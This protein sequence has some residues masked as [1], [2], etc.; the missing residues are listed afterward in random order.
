MQI[1]HLNQEGLH[2]SEKDAINALAKA[3]PDSWYGFASLEMF[4]RK[5]GSFETD[6]IILTHDRIIVAELKCWGGTI[7]SR[8][9]K[10]IIDWGNSQE[11][12]KHPIKQVSRAAKILSAKIQKKLERKVFI[13]WVD[14]CVILCGTAGKANLPDDEKGFVYTVDEFSQFGSP[15][16]YQ[17]V[18]TPPY[19]RYNP[20][21]N[22]ERPNQNINIWKNFFTGNSVDF[23]PKTFSVNNY[24]Q[25]GM[26]LYSHGQIYSEYLAQ[27]IDDSNYKSLMRRWDFSAPALVEQAQT[28]E[29]RKLIG[30]RESKVLGYLASQDESLQQ[31]HLQ[32]LYTPS[33]NDITTDFV[34]LYKWPG[35]RLRLDDFIAKNSKKISHQGRIELIKVF[36]SQLARLH[37]VDVAHRDIGKHSVWLSLPSK[38]TFS[39]FLTASYPDP[40]QQ[41]V[42]SVRDILKSGRIE[43]PEDLYEDKD[44]TAFTR[45]VYLAG[46]VAHYIAYD[47]WPSKLED[48]TYGWISKGDTFAGGLLD[49]WFEHCLDLEAKNR[50]SNMGCAL[51]ELNKLLS[52]Q[53]TNNISSTELEKFYSDTNVYM[54]YAPALIKQK[55]TASSLMRS[56][57]GLFGIILWF[58]INQFTP[59]KRI[60]FELASFLERVNS[61]KN[62][63]LPSVV[64]VEDF[65][66]NQ[67]MQSLFVIYKWVDGAIWSEWLQQQSDET[68]LARVALSL[69]R[70]ISQLHRSQFIHGDIH[71]ANI[72]I[73]ET[74]GQNHPVL[75]DIFNYQANV[76]ATPYNPNYVPTNYEQISLVSRDRFASVK[77]VCELAEKFRLIHLESYCSELLRQAEISEGDFDRLIDN[78]DDIIN[79]PPVNTLKKYEISTRYL[80]NFEI[81][82]SDDGIYYISFKIE[83][84]DDGSI[85]KAFISGTQQQVD[86][87]IDIDKKVIKKIYPREFITHH[88]FINNKRRSDAEFEGVITF[89]NG[90][91]LIADELLADLLSLTPAKE[92][93]KANSEDNFS[94][95]KFETREILTLK[96]APITVKSS[97]IWRALVETENETQPK[98]TVTREPELLMNGELL[99]HFSK[100][101]ESVDFDLRQ[102]KVQVKSDINGNPVL[103]GRLLDIG[104]DVL[105]IGGNNVRRRTPISPG[106]ILRLESSLAA[107]SLAKREKAVKN[108]LDGRAII[109]NI[110]DYFDINEIIIPRIFAE[111]PTEEEL[112]SYNVVDEN[113]IIFKL[114]QKQREAFKSL[115]RYGPVSLLQGPPGTGKTSFISSFIHYAVSKGA[116]RIL[117]VS[118]SHEAVNNAAEKVRKL[119][120]NQDKNIQIVRLGDEGNVSNALQDVHELALQEHYR[121]LFRAEF[122]DRIKGVVKTLGLTPEFVDIAIEFES[123]FG[124]KISSHL[125]AM[126]S[127]DDDTLKLFLERESNLLNKVYGWLERKGIQEVKAD[128]FPLS[129]IKAA[130]Y[131]ALANKHDVYSADAIYRFQQ[132][133]ALSGEWLEVMS[134]R[135][136]HFQNFLTKTR[137]LVCGTCVGI[138]RN[139]Y[140][141]GENIYDWVIIDEAA[142]STA[143]EMAIAMLIGR[144][145]LLVGDHQQLPPTYEEDHI[146]AAHRKLPEV[147]ADEL[148]RSDFE[149]SFNSSYGRKVGQ[150]L[151]TQYRMAKPIGDLVSTCFYKGELETG[152]KNVEDIYLTLPTFLGK[153]VN[154]VD[155]S[156][157]GYLAYDKKSNHTNANDHSVVNDYEAN[158]IINLI[159]LLTS[160]RLL[161]ERLHSVHHED[162]PI[163]IICMYSEQ[164]RLLIRKLNS[165]SWTRSLL[166]SRFIKVDTVDSYQGKENEIIILSLVR[167]NREGKEGFLSSENRANV[168]LSRAKEKLYIVGASTMWSENNNSSVFGMV[169]NYIRDNNEHCTFLDAI[170]INNKEE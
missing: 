7:F 5:E 44:G 155:T 40:D 84:I 99:V 85:L 167:F 158:T 54:S 13:P 161:L 140:G 48:G 56:G 162:S 35:A 153:T 16:K 22:T 29:E 6:L 143:S 73:S 156:Q 150:K 136:A 149:R 57:D 11:E 129:E 65:G 2:R 142:R 80:P 130:F 1:H 33:P 19:T 53:A 42:T 100:D 52:Q 97:S 111:E 157:A 58:G 63:Q 107:A 166:E 151:L 72:V 49:N 50:F 30:F 115:Y 160:E 139:H 31:V 83:K 10:W 141:I 148:A 51:D 145:V 133:I 95:I 45:D 69:L 64:A 78:Y 102:E 165:L 154:W 38:V 39:N 27:R 128:S 163:G 103:I 109:T 120:Q 75:I 62:A 108:I 170:K 25:T 4:D 26:A 159:Q 68:E 96:R 125:K 146:K 91:G 79:P 124:M 67:S 112:D 17:A 87:H 168:A 74:N 36:V 21:S 18:F 23:K 88:Q 12:R 81:M 93:I 131:S 94:K 70:G 105:R 169:Y 144:R 32:L 126:S 135:N 118:Q 127:K 59:D 9:G 147:S 89:K 117:L 47:C 43:I 46:A 8:N 24:A 98:V 152:R 14:Y 121:E 77:I 110:V 34:E 119:F 61:F 92:K 116:S 114:N 76:N 41:T 15:S 113:Q 90:A 137:T 37:E 82:S 86:L 104:K 164:R 101:S 20:K 134:S 60:N 28:Q 66:F 55:S 132:I 122:K 3:L 123:S 138:G 106:D 71:P